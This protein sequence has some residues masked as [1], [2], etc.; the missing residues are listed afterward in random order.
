MAKSMLE[1]LKEKG[2]VDPKAAALVE[3]K[4]ERE[5]KRDEQ[6]SNALI[7]SRGYED[8]E[9]LIKDERFHRGAAK[10]GRNAA[11]RVGTKQY[12]DRFKGK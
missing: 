6:R 7:H 11:S 2:L 1:A 10:E 4:R 12:M 8:H 9:R 3:A 5:L